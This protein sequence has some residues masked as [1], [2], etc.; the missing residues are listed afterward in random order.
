MPSRQDPWGVSEQDL[1]NGVCW[2][3]GEDQGEISHQCASQ[4]IRA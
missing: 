4:G 2:G 3:G 1:D